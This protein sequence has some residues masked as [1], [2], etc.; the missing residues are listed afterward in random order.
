M[1]PRQRRRCGRRRRG[2]GAAGEGGGSPPTPTPPP[3]TPLATP[4]PATATAALVP[5]QPEATPP[6][7]TATAALVI[8][9]TGGGG[10]VIEM[11]VGDQLMLVQPH[12][13]QPGETIAGIAA[14]N[15]V[16]VR[17]LIA[18]NEGIVRPNAIVAGMEIV[19]P[20]ATVEAVAE[21]TEPPAPP[22]ETPTDTPTGT[23]TETAT[24]TPTETATVTP[25]ETPTETPTPRPTNTPAPTPRPA[26]E[27]AALFPVTMTVGSTAEVL[28]EIAVEDV[29]VPADAGL[30]G[31]VEMAS[32]FVQTNRPLAEIYP[33]MLARLT[34]LGDDFVVTPLGAGGL[35]WQ[36]MRDGSA[37]WRWQVEALRP[38]RLPLTVEVMGREE[39]EGG[40]VDQLRAFQVVVAAVEEPPLKDEAENP[41]PV[42]GLVSPVMAGLALLVALLGAF[43]RR[44]EKVVNRYADVAP[45]LEPRRA[46][47]V[48]DALLSAFPAR[49]LLAQFTELELGLNLEVV[50][51]VRTLGD[52]VLDLMRWAQAQGRL[53]ELVEKA[54]AAVP[55]NPELQK[56]AAEFKT[57][58]VA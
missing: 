40:A 37:Y 42:A 25:T 38:G 22:T 7:A 1:R 8:P 28:V 54:I 11:V 43:V 47:Q 14:A 30:T 53:A 21:A 16:T 49:D 39:P 46:K 3:P 13:V 58:G 57:W 48:H 27:V 31:N 55:G 32:P 15:D 23:P 44:R 36:S 52:G 5:A 2:A 6:P 50:S 41:P 34:G 17:E 20:I 24:E 9:P 12:T 29:I 18:A 26:G 45:G 35:E 19:I 56:L 10:E 33:F 51:D 4:P